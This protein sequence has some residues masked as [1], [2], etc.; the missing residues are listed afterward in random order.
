MDYLKLFEKDL[1]FGGRFPACFA[2]SIHKAGSTLMNNMIADACVASR[3]P[4]INIPYI[5]F[6]EG[7]K[8]HHWRG[9]RQLLEFFGDGRIYYGFR[10]LPEVLLEP[11]V[12]LRRSKS[13]LLVRDPRDAL[14]SQFYSFGGRN[15][16][17]RLPPK[18]AEKFLESWEKTKHLA[19]DQYVLSSAPQH[20]KELLA[21]KDGLDP[22]N[23][24]LCRYEQAYFDKRTFLGGIFDHFSIPVP[25]EILDRVAARH[26]VRPESEDPTK[27]IRKGTP[28]D[29]RE[30]LRPE[31]IARLNDIFRDIC[32]WY[33]YE[34][35]A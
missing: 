15:I 2:F 25:A 31:T 9:D 13:V 33:G 16:S 20:L 21:Y 22:D 27:H 35:D 3:I 34:L 24:L 11:E 1:R 19:I 28:G 30:K 17:H 12:H 5:L 10:F 14:V 29:Y 7:M 8:D 23:V 18:Y 4:A 26:D 6:K 32:R